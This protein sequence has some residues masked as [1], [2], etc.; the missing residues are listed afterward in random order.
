MNAQE[1]FDRVAHHLAVQQVPSMMKKG[2]N[3]FCAYRG[4]NGTKCAIGAL[5]PDDVYDPHIEGKRVTALVDGAHPGEMRPIDK[6][7]ID[8][9]QH[10]SSDLSQLAYELQV[11]H[12]KAMK[13]LAQGNTEIRTTW[14]NALA[15]I[16]SYNHLKFDDEKFN[17]TWAANK[18]A[19]PCVKSEYSS[20]VC[21]RGCKS[22]DVR[23]NDQNS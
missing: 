3:E 15:I 2:N 1:M 18:K 4:T 13:V 22:C 10:R 17:E 7:L 20:R 11:A 14:L 8:T 19:D 6:F 16:A 21:E 23:H 9:F 5:I 12:D